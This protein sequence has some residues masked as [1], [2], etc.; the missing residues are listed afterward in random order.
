MKVIRKYFPKGSEWPL[1]NAM[2][3]YHGTDTTRGGIFR[4]TDKILDE[5]KACG[6]PEPENIR[7]AVRASQAL[8]AGGVLDLIEHYCSDPEFGGFLL[9]NVAD[10]WP[11]QS[12]A[13]LDCEGEAKPVF[14]K[15]GAAFRKARRGAFGRREGKA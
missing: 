10:C 11:Q 15:L 6:R 5:L 3:R 4:V 9:W 14:R 2:W 7:E 12:D 8:Q 1:T 13:V